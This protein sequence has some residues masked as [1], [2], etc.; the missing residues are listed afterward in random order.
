MKKSKCKPYKV[1]AWMTVWSTGE[2]AVLQPTRDAAQELATIL[3]ESGLK[4]RVVRCQEVSDD[5]K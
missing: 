3:N 2:S 1:A 4:A 5:C